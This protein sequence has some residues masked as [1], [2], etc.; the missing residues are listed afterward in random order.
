MRT[1]LYA[2]V[3]TPYKG[4][5]TANQLRQLRECCQVQRWLVLQEYE[6][7]SREGN[8]IALHFN[9]CCATR[10]REGLTSCSFG[11]GTD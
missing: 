2:R 3:S 9:K 6:T 7:T 5:E 8:A 4:E 1:A 10:L 11:P